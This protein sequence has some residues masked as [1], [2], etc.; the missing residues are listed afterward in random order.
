MG[1]AA[2][3]A[4]M[5]LV[6][7]GGGEAPG[8][9]TPVPGTP[10]ASASPMGMPATPADTPPVAATWPPEAE[11]A[12]VKAKQDLARKTGVAASAITV[13]SVTPQDWPTSG[14]GCEKP[15]QA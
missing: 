6:S 9:S 11:V 4:G 5:V 15:G 13:V 3:V 1:I 7:C 8:T 2:L 10:P 14:L 12:V